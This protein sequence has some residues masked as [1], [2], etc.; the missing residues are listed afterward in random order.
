MQ[1][2]LDYLSLLF[3]DHPTLPGDP[4]NPLKEF[5]SVASNDTA[6]LLPSKHCAFK[7]CSWC[8]TDA[9]S[10]V[11]HLMERHEEEYLRPAMTCFQALRPHVRSDARVLAL[12]VYSEGIAIAVRR[13]APLASYSIDRR[14]LKE[15]MTSLTHPGTNAVVCLLCAR[16][17]PQVHNG[18]DKKIAMRKLLTEDVDIKKSLRLGNIS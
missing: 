10:Q 12:S 14:C 11:N 3:R 16:R 15:Y 1:E 9:E 17:F 7:G 4:A 6:L 18:K 5:P 13:G 8:G 2:A